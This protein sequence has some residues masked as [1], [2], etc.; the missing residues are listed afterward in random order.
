MVEAARVEPGR[1]SSQVSDNVNTTGSDGGAAHRLTHKQLT[2][3][4][5]NGLDL[6]VDDRNCPNIL[7]RPLLNILMLA[8]S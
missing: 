2:P 8:K 6:G 3:T 4:V 1:E 5:P 7:K